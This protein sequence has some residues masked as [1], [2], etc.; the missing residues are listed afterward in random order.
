MNGNYE[1]VATLNDRKPD[2]EGLH[3]V[4]VSSTSKGNSALIP[5]AGKLIRERLIFCGDDHFS[6]QF[7]EKFKVEN[8]RSVVPGDQ[9]TQHERNYVIDPVNPKHYADLIKDLRSNG[10]LPEEILFLWNFSSPQSTA[11][12]IEQALAASPVLAAACLIQAFDNQ[13]IGA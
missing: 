2:G 11:L 10:R 7:V 9:F 4:F 8:T 1:S 6:A 5:K 12:S 13:G 3:T